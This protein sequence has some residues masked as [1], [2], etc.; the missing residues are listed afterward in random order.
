MSHRSWHADKPETHYK[1]QTALEASKTAS[2]PIS[3]T[4]LLLT[5]PLINGP[6]HGASTTQRVDEFGQPPSALTMP[7]QPKSAYRF[8]PERKDY[9]W[10]TATPGAGGIPGP[11][12][13]LSRE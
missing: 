7:D 11:V 9:V 6:H 10:W 3:R 1:S 8:S 4:H 13:K 12:L 2:K 5:Y